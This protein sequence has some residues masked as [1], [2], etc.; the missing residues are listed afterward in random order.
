[1]GESRAASTRL[2]CS[3]YYTSREIPIQNPRRRTVDIIMPSFEMRGIYCLA[4]VGR[5]VGLSID[6]MVSDQ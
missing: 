1:M 5:S 4:D 6:Q 2:R 3:R